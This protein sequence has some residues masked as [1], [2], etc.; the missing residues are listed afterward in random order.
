MGRITGKSIG[1]ERNWGDQPGQSGAAELELLL[2]VAAVCRKSWAADEVL[3]FLSTKMLLIYFCL[4][5]HLLECVCAYIFMCVDT[6]TYLPTSTCTKMRIFPQPIPVR[7]LQKYR[8]KNKI[9]LL[10]IAKSSETNIT[11]AGH[12]FPELSPLQDPNLMFL[13]VAL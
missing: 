5:I 7:K 13:S 6:H 8:A 9:K 2:V 4:C 12:N 3:C 10:I 11:D 1:Q